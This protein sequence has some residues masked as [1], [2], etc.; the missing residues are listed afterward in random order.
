M[1][2]EARDGENRL[3]Q[4]S[5]SSPPVVEGGRTSQVAVKQRSLC[6]FQCAR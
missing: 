4:S 5:S 2:S 6:F 3:A 1:R